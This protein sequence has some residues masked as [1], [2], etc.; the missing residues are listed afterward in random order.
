MNY[1]KKT[2]VSLLMLASLFGTSVAAAPYAY[3]ANCSGDGFLGMPSWYKGLVDSS[4]DDCNLKQP[5]KNGAPQLT[6]YIARIALN[7]VEMGLYL[8]GYVSV[9]FIIYGGFKYLTSPSDSSKITGA[10]KTIQNAVIGLVLSML[11]V[12][13]IKL[14]A[15][16]II[17]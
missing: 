2:L 10:R 8:V 12:A 9:G 1:L 17:K 3:A 14:I 5:G 4:T 11:S 16:N 7:V 13:I 6:G 15:D